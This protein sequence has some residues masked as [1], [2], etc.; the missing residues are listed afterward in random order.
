MWK[1]FDLITQYMAAYKAK[2][3]QATALMQIKNSKKFPEMKKTCYEHN[4]AKVQ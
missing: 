1:F 2:F 4:K 3:L